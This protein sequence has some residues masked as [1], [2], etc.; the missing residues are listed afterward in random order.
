MRWSLL[1][2]GYFGRTRRVK[3][4]KLYQFSIEFVEEQIMWNFYENAIRSIIGRLMHVC[5][6]NC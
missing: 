2:S 5:V 1:S 3:K 6:G 4:D